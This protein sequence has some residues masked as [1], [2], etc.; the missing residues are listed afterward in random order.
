MKARGKRVPKRA[1][2]PWIMSAIKRRAL[3][4]LSVYESQRGPL[5]RRTLLECDC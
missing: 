3:K 1:R 5:Q 2:R 4:S